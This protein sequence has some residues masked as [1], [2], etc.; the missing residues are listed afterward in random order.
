M[1]NN[2]IGNCALTGKRCELQNS[3]IYPKFIYNH[4]KK[5][6]GGRF[7]IANNPNQALQDGLKKHLLGGWA[8]QE[9]SKREK[10]FAENIFFPF[11]NG[12]LTDMKVEYDEQLYY[13][14]ISLL[15]RVLHLTK[16]N[17]NGDK[18][19]RKCNEALEE[20]RSYLNGGNL[21][22]MYGSIYLMPITP[23]L[24]DKEQMILPGTREF[25]EV[26][27]YIRRLFDSDLF[28]LI[29]NNNIF[30][31]KIP[32]FFFWAV[33]ERD[34]QQMNYG[35]RILPNGGIIDFKNYHIS[36]GYVKE[37]V[38]LRILLAAQKAEEV[39][40]NMS[41]EQQDK[42]LQFTLHDNHLR[43]SELADLLIQMGMAQ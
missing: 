38:L 32:Y 17:I 27:W 20:W 6:G 19:R 22:N 10:W 7:R 13:F 24:F 4:L 21:P 12:R 3:H 2:I 36:N 40:E 15:W 26:Q 1:A 42:I 25:V 43:D 8:E 34:N 39:G 29:P 37:Y 5:T 35:L 33:I 30:F 16:D 41:K 28:G 11:V 23:E 9:F 14:C 31:C 18:E